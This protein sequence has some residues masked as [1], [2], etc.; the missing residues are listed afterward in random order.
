MTAPTQPEE[1]RVS[2]SAVVLVALA[3]VL[4]IAGAIYWVIS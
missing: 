2:G 4:A 3:V 1:N